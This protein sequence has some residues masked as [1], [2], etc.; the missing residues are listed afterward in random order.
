MNNNIAGNDN[1]SGPDRLCQW[2]LQ[3]LAISGV[4]ARMFR[5]SRSRS[6]VTPSRAGQ[7]PYSEWLHANSPPYIAIELIKPHVAEE[8]ASHHARLP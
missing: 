7:L 1:S 6:A 8:K 5:G 3:T 2:L 4:T